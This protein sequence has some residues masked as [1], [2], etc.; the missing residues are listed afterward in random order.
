MNPLRSAQT[1][2]TRLCTNGRPCPRDC[3]GNRLSQPCSHAA[4]ARPTW[5]SLAL[6]TPTQHS[7]SMS[8]VA[9]LR[10]HAWAYP[11]LEAVHI[12]GTALLLGNL[13]ALEV[14]LGL[15]TSSLPIQDEKGE[16][17]MRVDYLFVN[18]KGYGLRSSPA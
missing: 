14:R 13:L 4:Q 15:P 11:V 5:A 10:A 6:R 9:A 12:I 16:T 18:G 2:T 8:F 7:G 17:V 1:L 3:V